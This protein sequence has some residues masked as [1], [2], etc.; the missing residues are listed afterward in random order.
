MTRTRSSRFSRLAAILLLPVVV[1]QAYAAEV[2]A[3]ALVNPTVTE[4]GEPVQLQ[5]EVENARGRIM[6][7]EVSVDGLAINYRGSSQSQ[8]MQMGT[9]GYS[10]VSKLSLNYE[11]VPRREGQFTIPAQTV[12]VDGKTLQT[13]P[14]VLKVQKGAGGQARGDSSPAKA[15]G[16]IELKQ[17]N[18]YVGEAVPIEVRLFVEERA[19]VGEVGGFVLAG[20]GFTAQK[21]PKF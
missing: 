7:P 10:S 19:R 1:C 4:V 13:K 21:F 16:E 17:K 3:R 2:T 15:F 20:E 18:V 6:T 11:V 5:I 9:G 14:V 8:Q 12:V